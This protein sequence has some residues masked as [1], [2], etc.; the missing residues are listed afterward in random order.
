MKEYTLVG[1]FKDATTKIHCGK[2]IIKGIQPQVKEK[3]LK[4]INEETKNGKTSIQIG[5]IGKRY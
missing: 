1:T 5:F 3:M 2:P 4:L